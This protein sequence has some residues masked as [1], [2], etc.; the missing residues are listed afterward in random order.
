VITLSDCDVSRGKEGD[1]GEDGDEDEGGN[2][3]AVV[4]GL[5]LVAA[6]RFTRTHGVE[7][8][9]TGNLKKEFKIN[10]IVNSEK[11]NSF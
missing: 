5:G 8:F 4:D 6:V 9:V 1:E 3:V 10:F 11:N 2:H 7:V